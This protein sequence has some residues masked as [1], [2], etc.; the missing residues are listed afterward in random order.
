MAENNINLEH[1]D[2]PN[3]GANL[4]NSKG[5]SQF[6]IALDQREQLTRQEYEI[7]ELRKQ[8]GKIEKS[9]AEKLNAEWEGRVMAVEKEFTA[10]QTSRAFWTVFIIS[11][12]LFIIVYSIISNFR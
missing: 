1:M 6:E 4:G 9:T 7:N 11:A 8:I 12:V 2:R 5:K 10:K 3:V